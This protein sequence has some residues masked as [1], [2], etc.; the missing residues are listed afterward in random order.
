MFRKNLDGIHVTNVQN[1][2]EKKMDLGSNPS[3]YLCLQF[4]TIGKEWERGTLQN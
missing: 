4:N 2:K 1:W 3:F